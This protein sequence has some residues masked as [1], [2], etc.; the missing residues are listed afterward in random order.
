MECLIS[1]YYNIHWFRPCGESGG[2]TVAVS[3]GGGGG[4]SGRTF[5]PF[6]IF[7]KSSPVILYL[8]GPPRAPQGLG[9][10]YTRDS[11]TIWSDRVTWR[12]DVIWLALVSWLRRGTATSWYGLTSRVGT[13]LRHQWKTKQA[14]SANVSLKFT[15]G[16]HT[17]I[18]IPRINVYIRLYHLKKKIYSIFL[19]ISVSVTCSRDYGLRPVKRGCVVHCVT[20]KNPKS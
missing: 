19:V 1:A 18:F 3:T 10:S 6:N 14:I 8:K 4:G 11:V 13:L 5:T 16:W 12:Q 9:T 7:S 17:L 20:S 15:K 2:A